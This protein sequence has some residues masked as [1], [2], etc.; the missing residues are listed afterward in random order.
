MGYLLSFAIFSFLIGCYLYYEFL[1]E[2]L[3]A[4]MMIWGGLI[5]I[6]GFC[7]SLSGENKIN[8]LNVLNVIAVFICAFSLEENTAFLLRKLKAYVKEKKKSN[9]NENDILTNTDL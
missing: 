9:E 4:R 2:G 8:D 3:L 7:F 6:L 5:G 1:K